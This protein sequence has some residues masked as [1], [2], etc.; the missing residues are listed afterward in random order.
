MKTRELAEAFACPHLHATLTRS[1]CAARYRSFQSKGHHKSKDGHSRGNEGI[2]G[3][4]CRSCDIGA[5]HAKGKLVPDVALASI[6]ARPTKF[7]RRQRHCLG[8]G[9]PIPPPSVPRSDR[10]WHTNRRVCGPACASLVN[11]SKRNLHRVQLP[12]WA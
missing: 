12:E 3:C 7:R 1:S 10:F 4:C 5:A 6:V 9:D 8:C 11:E 2:T